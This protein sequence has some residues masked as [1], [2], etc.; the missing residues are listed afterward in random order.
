MDHDA[1]A[2]TLAEL[3]NR[4]RLAIFRYL[5]KAGHQGAS[6]G[7]IQRALDIP[8][9]TLSHHL[10][11]MVH[12]ALVAQ[13][14]QWRTLFSQANCA[15]LYAVMDFLS[16]QCCA[17]HPETPVHELMGHDEEAD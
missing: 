3:G 13:R 14:R 7:E 6:V 5:V 12:V 8:P 16:E 11:R 9:S 10:T 2:E 15:Q 17:G 1:A 4:H